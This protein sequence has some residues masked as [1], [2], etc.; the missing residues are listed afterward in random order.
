MYTLRK[1]F[2]ARFYDQKSLLWTPVRNFGI[3]M[4]KIKFVRYPRSIIRK[5]H[6]HPSSLFVTIPAKIVKQW[7]LNPGELVEFMVATEGSES[8]VKIRK[9]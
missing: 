8:F 7:S 3:H 2:V 1:L 5:R 9:V 6:D 4:S